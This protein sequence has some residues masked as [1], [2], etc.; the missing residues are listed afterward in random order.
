MQYCKTTTKVVS[1]PSILRQIGCYPHVSSAN[2]GKLLPN[3][4]R[5]RHQHHDHKPI[6]AA[7]NPDLHRNM[8]R[9]PRDC[10]AFS[11]GICATSSTLKKEHLNYWD[12]KKSTGN[13]GIQITARAT[14]IQP[15]FSQRKIALKWTKRPIWTNW[16]N[17]TVRLSHR[18]CQARHTRIMTPKT[19]MAFTGQI[20][21]PPL[22]TLMTWHCEAKSSILTSVYGVKSR[23]VSN[24]RQMKRTKVQN[25]QFLR[26]LITTKSVYGHL[27]RTPA[28]PPNTLSKHSI[29]HQ[30]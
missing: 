26:T 16:P 28:L 30:W 1:S 24:Y 14:Y 13:A 12:F 4:W 25:H 6:T 5:Y 3:Q 19:A 15:K 17:S 2:A 7:L 22:R 9:W 27:F 11:A 8:N 29:K 18:N 10:K 21:R 20:F 23:K